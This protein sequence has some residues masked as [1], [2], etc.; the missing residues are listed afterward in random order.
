MTD[1]MTVDDWRDYLKNFNGD[2]EI[3]YAKIEMEEIDA[4]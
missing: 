3:I 4:D 2:R 1:T